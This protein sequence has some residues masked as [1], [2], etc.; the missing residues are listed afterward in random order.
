ML[1]VYSAFA[2]GWV[3]RRFTEGIPDPQTGDTSA[4]TW[5]PPVG[6]IPLI[7]LHTLVVLAFAVWI[8]R[9][10]RAAAGRD[11]AAAAERDDTAGVPTAGARGTDATRA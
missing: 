2:Y 7:V 4:T 1:A 11:D 5:Q 6:E 9:L 10:A 8:G 3:L